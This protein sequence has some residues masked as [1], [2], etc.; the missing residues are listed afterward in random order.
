ML[1]Y[2]CGHQSSQLAIGRSQT[3]Y[4]VKPRCQ[5]QEIWN[6][7]LACKGM[8]SAAGGLPQKLE[9]R[10]SKV[11]RLEARPSKVQADDAPA[12]DTETCSLPAAAVRTEASSKNKGCSPAHSDL[13][14]ETLPLD[15]WDQPTDMEVDDDDWDNTLKHNPPRELTLAYTD[16]LLGQKDEECYCQWVQCCGKWQKWT[17]NYH[18]W[19]EKK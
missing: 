12:P 10:P 14:A 1:C 17:C 3:I 5:A 9:A 19:E 6:T 4:I 2:L 11:Q 7:R 15:F 18:R 8:T 13:S 16:W